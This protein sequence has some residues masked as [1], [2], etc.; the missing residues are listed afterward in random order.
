FIFSFNYDNL[1]CHSYL[2]ASSDKY[3]EKLR[4]KKKKQCSVD[5]ETGSQTSVFVKRFTTVGELNQPDLSIYLNF[6]L[7]FLMLSPPLSHISLQEHGIKFGRLHTILQ[8]F[9]SLMLTPFEIWYLCMAIISDSVNE[10]FGN[11]PALFA[12]RNQAFILLIKCETYAMIALMQNSKNRIAKLIKLKQLLQTISKE[13]VLQTFFPNQLLP[14]SA[15]NE[16]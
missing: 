3:T 11:L 15:R 4:G 14:N 8:N 5:Q 16:L 1:R 9:D 13:T 10:I 2:I 12:Y 6:M 7:R